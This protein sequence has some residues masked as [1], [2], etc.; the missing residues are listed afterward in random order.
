MSDDNVDMVERTHSG[1]FIALLGFAVMASAG[2]LIWAYTLENRLEKSQT[3]LV[4]AQQQN[5]KLA[6]SLSESERSPETYEQDMEVLRLPFPEALNAAL[7]GEIVHSGS[8]TALC[9]AARALRLL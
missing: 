3:A 8:V 2:A 5:D 1:V 6:E 9:R 4:N 7:E